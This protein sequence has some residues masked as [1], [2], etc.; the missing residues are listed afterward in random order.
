MRK[1]FSEIKVLESIKIERERE[2]TFSIEGC[3]LNSLLSR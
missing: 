2:I 1:L 3:M